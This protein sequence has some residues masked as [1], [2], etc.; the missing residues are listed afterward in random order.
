MLEQHRAAIVAA[1]QSVPQIG[2]VHDRE[3]YADGEAK[4][5]S[6]YLYTPAGGAPE[7]RGWWLRRSATR[8]HSPSVARALNAHTWSIRGY[9]SF[10]DDDATELVLDGLVEQFRSVVRAD[11]TLG[12]VVQPGPLDSQEDGVQVMDAGPVRFAGLICHSAV[13][14]LTTWSYL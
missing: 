6:L 13:L 2:I 7:V 1:L 11:P 10:R 8:E 3:R 9:M 5:R 4:F 14:Q 12:G